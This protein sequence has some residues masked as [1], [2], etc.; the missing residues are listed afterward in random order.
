MGVEFGPRSVNRQ[1]GCRTEVVYLYHAGRTED[2]PACHGLARHRSSHRKTA[3][4]RGPAYL[5]LHAA[6]LRWRTMSVGF[7]D[8]QPCSRKSRHSSNGAAS[9]RQGRGTACWRAATPI[10]PQCRHFAIDTGP[11][12][13]GVIRK[14]DEAA[15]SQSAWPDLPPARPLSRVQGGLGS[16]RRHDSISNLAARDHFPAPPLPPASRLTVACSP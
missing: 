11:Y 12:V 9:H 1:C 4:R 6:P 14:L 3:F 10:E 8:R 2:V 13:D 5:H 7:G 15:P 16:D